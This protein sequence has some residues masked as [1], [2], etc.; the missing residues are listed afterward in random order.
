MATLVGAD[1]LGVGNEVGSLRVGK[2]ADLL[3][4]AGNPA[5]D[6][7]DIEKVELVFKDGVAY[8]PR[9]LRESAKGQVGWH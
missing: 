1:F 7:R 8:D 6:M 9:L 5:A 2:A 3:V 4:V